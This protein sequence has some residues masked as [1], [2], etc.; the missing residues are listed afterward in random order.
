MFAWGVPGSILM[1][2]AKGKG[3]GAKGNG[4]R[5]GVRRPILVDR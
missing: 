2:R 3:Q 5:H 4:E 1:G